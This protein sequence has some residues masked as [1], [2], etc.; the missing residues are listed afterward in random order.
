VQLWAVNQV[1]GEMARSRNAVWERGY[2]RPLGAHKSSRRTVAARVA[3]RGGDKLFLRRAAPPWLRSTT[4]SSRL[5]QTLCAAPID[6]LGTLLT[7][8]LE[9]YDDCTEKTCFCETV[10]IVCAR[11]ATADDTYLATKPQRAYSGWGR[12]R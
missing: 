6:Q 12:E 8:Q 5:D 2:S 4:R 3:L 11:K 10:H 9:S 7:F 1:P